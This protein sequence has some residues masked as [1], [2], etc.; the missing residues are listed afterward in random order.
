[1]IYLICICKKFSEILR[2]IN[3]VNISMGSFRQKCKNKLLHC[4]INWII[5]D[6]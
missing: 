4:Q 5:W 2:M 3:I 1:M 6:V